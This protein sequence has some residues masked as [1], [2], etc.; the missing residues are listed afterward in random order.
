MPSFSWKR[1][2]HFNADREFRIIASPEEI[3]IYLTRGPATIIVVQVKVRITIWQ[4][5]PLAPHEHRH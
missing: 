2:L 1:I 3:E 5:S 4:S